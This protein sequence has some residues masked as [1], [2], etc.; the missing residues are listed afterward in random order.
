MKNKKILLNVAFIIFSSLCLFPLLSCG[1]EHV[2]TWDSGTVTKEPNCTSTGEIVYKCTDCDETKTEELA[3]KHEFDGYICSLCGSYLETYYTEGLE[4]ELSSETTYK[5]KD[6][7]STDYSNVIIPS[8]YNGLKVTG[9]AEN[10]LYSFTSTSSDKITIPSSIT[11]IDYL[12]FG[13]ANG[14]NQELNFNE[15]ENGLYLGNPE[16]PYHVFVK[17]KDSNLPSI[18]FNEN[19]KIIYHFALDAPENIVI[20]NSVESIGYF[21]F[22]NTDNLKYNEYENGMYLGSEENP[23][24]TLLKVKNTSCSSFNINSNTKVIY[25]NAFSDCDSLTN[26]TI[27]DSVKEIGW[28]AF[29]SCDSLESV[30]LPKELSRIEEKTFYHCSALTNITI[31]DS[32]YHIGTNSFL[33]CSSLKNITIPDGIT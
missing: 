12:A 18:K 17:P 30:V 7:N 8:I 11:Y 31:P 20:P 24:H 28:G 19:T 4:F 16:N 1:K 29:E 3:R 25:T 5:V 23:Y 21:A 2:H 33:G 14:Y 26:I 32:V 15:Y 13:G 22:G 10:A 9:I 6:Y 27:P